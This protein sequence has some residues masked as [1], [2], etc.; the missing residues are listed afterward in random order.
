M[1][2]TTTTTRMYYLA[3]GAFWLVFG[4]I[5]VFKPG[6]MD[7]FQT[8]NGVQAKTAF[9]N[10]VWMHD[11]LDILAFCL[12][13][14]ALSRETVS[15]NVLRVTALAALM[16]TIGI[17]YSLLTTNYWSPLFIVAGLGCFAFVV[18][19]FLLSARIKR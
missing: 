14:F 17:T 6:L 16:P 3:M 19:G 4:L 15:R 1:T 9:S 7:L 13:L 10:H 5:T 2:T 12:L 11:G 8:A 18:W